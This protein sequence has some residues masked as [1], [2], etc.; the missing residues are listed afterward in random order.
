MS[1]SAKVRKHACLSSIFFT[2]WSF[3]CCSVVCLFLVFRGTPFS[4]C[5]LL[6]TIVSRLLPESIVIF[7][8]VLWTLMSLLYWQEYVYVHCN[9]VETKSSVTLI[10]LHWSSW[11]ASQS[12]TVIISFNSTDL[13]VLT[14]L[15]CFI[16]P[17]EWRKWR[18]KCLFLLTLLVFFSL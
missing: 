18:Y 5:V 13:E 1:C 17:K 2:L 11:L 3:C 15:F 16:R 9:E 12:T 4:Y 8:P 10:N 14:Q 7:T 6:K